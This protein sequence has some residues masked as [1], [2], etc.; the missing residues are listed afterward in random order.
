VEYGAEHEKAGTIRS[1]ELLPLV[2]GRSTL[3]GVYNQ[4][5]LLTHA[6]YYLASELG[7][8]SPNPFRSRE[9]SSF[10]TDGALRH[11]RLFNVREIVALSPQLVGALEARADVELAFR[12]PPYAVFR[13][14]DP[15]PGY[16]EAL[17]YAPVRSSPRHWREKAYR[18]FTRKPLSPAPLVFSEDARFAVGEPD[19]YLPPP[20]VPLAGGVEL[21]ARLDSESLT[22]RTSRPGHPL[23]VKIAY[24]PR[25]RAEGADGPFLVSPGMMLVVPK[26]TEVRLRYAART[27]ADWIGL[28]LSAAG[29]GWLVLNRR[30]AAPRTARAAARRL[31][32]LDE[33]GLPRPPR[34]W[35]GLVPAGL[36]ALLAASRLA[37]PS[38][39]ASARELPALQEKALEAFRAQRFA[40]AAEYLRHALAGGGGSGRRAELLC[41]RGESLLQAGRPREAL[42]AFATVQREQPASP[43]ASRALAGEALAHEALGDHAGAEAAR[44][45]LRREPP[46]LER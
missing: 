3:E 37:A 38:A 12:V 36:V 27:A 13:L 28:A 34:R 6:V 2:S 35:G 10:D 24:H 43:L 45:R 46:A 11:L 29:L 31:Q 20:L 30:A 1:Y 16:V 5:G 7:A 42:E 44:R 21:D 4:A 25:W 41:L 39:A 15:G 22:I 32:D 19:E 23:L 14:K 9:Y 26:Q 33:C 40:D 18:W 17:A 8:A